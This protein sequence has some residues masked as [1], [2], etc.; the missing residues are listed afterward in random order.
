MAALREQGFSLDDVATRFAVSRE[1]V[2]QILRVHGGPDPQAIVEARR[3]RAQRLAEARVDE[4]LV[5]WREG[6][7]PG[8]I[9]AG[10]GLQVA[11]TRI[12]IERFATDVDRAARMASMTG[13]RA[14]ALYSDDDIALALRSAASRLGRVP[15]PKDYATIARPLGYPSLATVVN[16]MGG[17]LNAVTSAGLR[18]RATATRSRPRR[19]TEQACWD[20]LRRAVDELDEI[21]GVQAY[22]RLAVGR[23]D[24]PSAAT[25]RNRLGR[26]SSIAARLAAQ[27]ELAE[28]AQIRAQSSADALARA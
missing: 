24:L 5:L 20:A 25:I 27:R 11:A 21:P 12:A 10:L 15:S 7:A 17:W 26:W 19:W 22:E 23:N 18:P 6:V 8:A 1:R 13:E 9:A 3:H 16:R 2:R 14:G 4:L 28:Q